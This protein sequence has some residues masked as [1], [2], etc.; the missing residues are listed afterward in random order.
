MDNRLQLPDP[1]IA[2]EI[3]DLAV[4]PLRNSILKM[5]SFSSILAQ[6]RLAP[7]L[8]EWR[9]FEY[10]HFYSAWVGI[11]FRFRA[12]AE[13]SQAFSVLFERSRGDTNGL[14]LYQEDEAIYGFFVKGLSA[15]E[16]FYYGL[17]AL[18]AL[19]CTPTDRLSVLPH[20]EFPLLTPFDDKRLKLIVPKVT[21]EVIARCFPN[22]SLSVMI[23]LI[24]KSAEYSSWSDIRNILAH[25][26][27]TVGR[28]M[29]MDLHNRPFAVRSWA[30]NIL[31]T[32]DLTSSYYAWLC[33]TLNAGLVAVD[34]F[35]TEHLN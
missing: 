10:Q 23:D 31:F 30:G 17:Y 18:G 2:I 24:L 13:H 29:Q 6:Q 8:W 21:K 16:C 9:R 25:R 34:A 15:L 35:V 12:C 27:G 19:I 3:P 32:A 26:I 11:A 28:S 14:E 7:E 20:P 5:Q 4:V 1:D 22:S 33:Q